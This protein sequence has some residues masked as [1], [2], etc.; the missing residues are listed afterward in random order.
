MASLKGPFIIP[1]I[2]GR[3]GWDDVIA[4]PDTLAAECLNIDPY[5]GGIGIKRHGIE[6]PSSDITL[7][8]DPVD[9]WSDSSIVFTGDEQLAS[10]KLVNFNSSELFLIG[11]Q[12]LGRI[13]G[14]SLGVASARQSSYPYAFSST[15]SELAQM[16]MAAINA[17]AF[18]AGNSAENRICWTSNLNNPSTMVRAGLKTPAAA[19]VA[20]TGAGA[21]AAT[22]R[23]Y[24]V[25]MV[26]LEG[27][28]VGPS[29]EVESN[30][31][32]AVAF[33]PS[34]GG[35]AAR[36]TK[37]A[38]VGESET[39]W[40]VYVSL[41]NRVYYLLA[42]VAIGTTTYDD[43]TATTAYSAGALAPVEGSLYPFPS[44]KFLLSAF[45][46]L[47]G[48]GRWETSAGDSILTRD[49]HLYFSPPR[50]TSDLHVEEI[51][52]NT[53]D[54]KGILPLAENASCVDRAL[55]GPVD[56]YIYA[57]QDRGI[58]RIRPTGVASNPFTSTAISLD[59]GAM[60]NR[61]TFI[62][63]DEY[64]RP[65]VY[66]LDPGK[67]PCRIGANGP[68]WIGKDCKDIWD[69]VNHKATVLTAHGIHVKDRNQLWWWVATGS[70]N[71][72]D[73][74]IVINVPAIGSAGHL[75]G[76]HY[77]WTGFSATVGLAAAMS[78][79]MHDV[80]LANP[81][82][83]VPYM[84]IPMTAGRT[85]P[86]TQPPFLYRVPFT[87]MN[88]ETVGSAGAFASQVTTKAFRDLGRYQKIER[89]YVLADAVTGGE[90][91]ASLTVNAGQASTGK[92]I[93][94]SLTPLGGQSLV[95]RK[96]DGLE[97]TEAWTWQLDVN[98]T[99][100]QAGQWCQWSI[101]SLHVVRSEGSEYGDT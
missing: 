2:Y 61:S 19:T 59:Y 25:S 26:R 86:T 48:F 57:F 77:K 27:G 50:G 93:Q 94:I 79:V 62:G 56:G 11:S 17:K 9:G 36:I 1:P 75:R 55:V 70:S 76:G 41:D 52:R 5:E 63:D 67:G 30:L 64:G 65:C 82:S 24:R 97:T 4:G 68:E 90:V 69:T 32:A 101:L 80:D 3:N 40:R 87:G 44:V 35:T 99:S 37:P 31:G 13:L 98:D 73:T 7:M 89:V 14:N 15:A 78:S 8:T 18:L 45:N 53:I 83:R 29:V 20:D 95:F 91:G 22:L 21:Y 42:T 43:S 58:Y 84:M 74:M 34:G 49:G 92:S 60:S 51:I 12:Q 38:S 54:D 88:L 100:T 85:T 72:P 96:V 28:G 46:R 39:H 33:T 66:F 10:F 23:Y 6:K 47:I 81:S 71:R 16:N